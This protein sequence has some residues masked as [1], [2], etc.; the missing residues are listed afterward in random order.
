MN[1]TKN[2]FKIMS[3][4]A[5]ALHDKCVTC[6]VSLFGDFAVMVVQSSD[7]FSIIENLTSRCVTEKELLTWLSV[8]EGDLK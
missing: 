1:D 3:L 8:I 2:K 6:T 7:D 4:I 5:L